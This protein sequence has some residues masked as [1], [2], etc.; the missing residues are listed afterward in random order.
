LTS[1]SSVTRG[2][3]GRRRRGGGRLP[4][5][6]YDIGDDFPVLT[7]EVTPRLDL[8][9]WTFTVDGLVAATR[10]WSW[11]ELQAMPHT[12]FDGGMHG[13]TA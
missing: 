9:N 11:A 10:T 6:Q 13:V 2:F 1:E 3:V 12:I 7:A 4:P 5:G 8:E